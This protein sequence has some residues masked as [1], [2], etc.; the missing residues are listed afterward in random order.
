MVHINSQRYIHIYLNKNK[1]SV[2]N[3]SSLEFET[4]YL[5]GSDAHLEGTF[6]ELK[7]FSKHGDKQGDLPSMMN[8]G[9]RDRIS[10]PPFLKPRSNNIYLPA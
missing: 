10:T 7:G 3:W 8:N 5:F 6:T 1:K 9:G 4:D 2:Q